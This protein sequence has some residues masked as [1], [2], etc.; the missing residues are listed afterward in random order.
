VRSVREGRTEQVEQAAQFIIDGAGRM[1]RL[2]SDL[3]MYTRV[4]VEG[5]DSNEL[6]DLNTAIAQA[7]D[8]LEASIQQ[9][10]AVVT[11]DALPTVRC[12]SIHAVE[13]F[14]NLIENAVKYHGE[15]PPAVHTSAQ[16]ADGEWRLTITDNGIG[17]D[18]Q[19]REQIFGVFK[20]LHN[21]DIPGTGIGLAICRR[22]VERSGGRIWVEPGVNGGS[23]F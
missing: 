12:R 5:S 21:R 18:T 15:H 20:R 22:I 14:Q 2:L 9:A 11:Y 6:V 19:Y 4:T 8:N 17:I 13:L 16:M 1:E 7:I 10:G 3:S 23:A